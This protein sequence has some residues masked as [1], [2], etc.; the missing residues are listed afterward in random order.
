MNL[1]VV[2]ASLICLLTLTAL[3]AFSAPAGS[4]PRAASKKSAATTELRGDPR[5]TKAVALAWAD[6][7]LGQA[8]P[9]LGKTLGVSLS[10]DRSVAD[11]QITFFCKER[12]ASDVL[13]LMA[14]HFGFL[15]RRQGQGYQLWQDLAGQQ[16]EAALR[17]AEVQDLLRRVNAQLERIAA[18][19]QLS[20]A[21]REV[22]QQQLNAAAAIPN[23]TS[24]QS[25]EGMLQFLAL[26]GVRDPF[27][28]VG[29]DLL[30]T[31]TPL[32]M[33]QLA[34]GVPVLFATADGSFPLAFAQRSRGVL[35]PELSELGPITGMR[36]T[37]R[38]KENVGYLMPDPTDEVNAEVDGALQFSGWV[39][40]TRTR[41]D[42]NQSSSSGAWQPFYTGSWS[43]DSV[44]P[45][46]APELL[47]EVQLIA[48]P[49]RRMIPLSEIAAHL[50]AATGMPILADS[51][52]RAR[53]REDVLSGKKPL[54]QFLRLLE[55]HLEYRW[56]WRDGTL[57]L[58]SGYFYRDRPREIPLRL[59]TLWRERL[60]KQG[61][62][63]LSDLAE[64]A[65]TLTDE[66]LRGLVSFWYWQFEEDSTHRPAGSPPTALAG[67]PENLAQR[68]HDL[69][70]WHS[71]NAA[72]R[73][74]ATRGVLSLRSLNGVLQRLAL[75][76]FLTPQ[77][78]Y[79]TNEALPSSTPD[80]F[81]SGG[82]S[83][84]REE[85]QKFKYTV[86][87]P[88]GSGS[89]SEGPLALEAPLPPLPEL[90]EGD[91][92]RRSVRKR[93]LIQFRYFL[94][95]NDQPASTKPLE[96]T[97]APTTLR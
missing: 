31:L 48:K 27:N 77:E 88:N 19:A 81:A 93:S 42:G 84:T 5:L 12:P 78:H 57:R 32:Q 94:P 7:T 82:F 60:V 64:L 36:V 56:E 51:F 44:P 8:L 40:T 21:E 23:R 72:Q 39:T 45:P 58:R 9:E 75:T 22:K 20:P 29:R 37:F 92:L 87:N 76:A 18:M 80:Q 25:Q 4:S 46:E 28:L 69:R 26:V 79:D 97:H 41:S 53:V 13:P 43:R 47:Q 62:F 55:Q 66:Q 65:A 1:R 50:Q 54:Y 15:W 74:R 68:R 89:G 86:R 34:Q 14:S 33:R 11:D 96:I 71:L 70:L 38:V 16:R 67:P 3:G 30:R 91:V 17:Q 52:I 24:E 90:A 95:G 63:S 61:A 6:R 10:A 35:P 2:V 73:E 49:G 85:G 59:R 83:I